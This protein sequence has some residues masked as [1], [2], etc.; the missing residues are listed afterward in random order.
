[1]IHKK[2]LATLIT[3]LLFISCENEIKIEGKWY[4]VQSQSEKGT[5]KKSINKWIEFYSNGTLIG[6]KKGESEI[7]NGIWKYDSIDNKL[8]ID[9][10]KKYGGEGVYTLEKLSENEMIMVNDSL[11]IYFKK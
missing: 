10:K 2:L 4:V 5:L 11:K 6:G 3:A 7:K 8:F 9:S 1:M